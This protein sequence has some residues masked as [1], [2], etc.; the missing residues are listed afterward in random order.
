[1]RVLVMIGLFYYSLLASVAWSCS[2]AEGIPPCQAYWQATAVFAGTVTQVSSLPYERTTGEQIVP[3]SQTLVHFTVQKAYKGVSAQELEVTTGRGS[4]DCGYPFRRGEQYLV[5]AMPDAQTKTLATSICTLT[6]PWAEAEPDLAYLRTI[7]TEQAGTRLYGRVRDDTR[8]RHGVPSSPVILSGATIRLTGPAGVQQV[9]SDSQGRYEWTH[10]PAGHYQLGATLPHYA[11]LSPRD[12][13]FELSGHGCFALDLRFQSNGQISGHVYD[14]HGTPLSRQRVE[15][16]EAE[17]NGL[18]ER[19]T[20]TDEEG[21]YQLSGVRPGDFLLGVNLSAPPDV[22]HPYLKTFS[23]SAPT[24]E[25][26]SLV[27]LE[28]AGQV[29]GQD[30]YLRTRCELRTV[31]GIVLWPDGQ[32]ATKATIMLVYPEYPWRSDSQQGPDAQGRFSVQVFTK[33]PTR[34]W[35]QAPNAKGVWM[36]A[37]PVE[38]P[39]EGTVPPLTLILNQEP[40]QWI[41]PR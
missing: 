24:R 3:S 23:P 31:Q 4:S 39:T 7:V 35:V 26:A 6:K 1:M 12:F 2:C 19:S 8:D 17:G 21:H 30:I 32:P 10:L 27:H 25:R 22:Q 20:E 13:S 9:T 38:L 28:R 40:P 29:R 11:P 18:S 33:L 36:N 34:L 41:P 37:G 15:L 14:E 16:M 5:Y